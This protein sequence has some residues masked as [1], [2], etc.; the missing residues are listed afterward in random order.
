M[1]KSLQFTAFVLNENLTE[2]HQNVYA[3]DEI[4]YFKNIYHI[5]PGLDDYQNPYKL[6]V[7]IECCQATY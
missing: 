2:I 7:I 5:Y 4:C 1:E 6:L 3:S